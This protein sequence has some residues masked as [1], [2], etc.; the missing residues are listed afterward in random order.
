METNQ[1]STGTL[2]LAL[3]GG[4]VLGA[5]AA[6]LYAPQSGR[7]TRQKLR[8]LS[9]D[10]EDCAQELLDKAKRQGGELLR[11]GRACCEEHLR[12]HGTDAS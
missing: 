5:G 10:A 1:G 7:R 3:I 4:A 2:L 12:S 8:D 11:K 6:L 9:E